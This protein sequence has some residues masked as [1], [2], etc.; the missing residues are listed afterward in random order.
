[1]Q[2]A[3]V[4]AL[5]FSTRRAGVDGS[6]VVSVFI[7]PVLCQG[8]RKVTWSLVCLVFWWLLEIFVTIFNEGITNA[9]FRIQSCLYMRLM[10]VYVSDVNACN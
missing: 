5:R 2:P 4:E 8:A 10:Q 9:V 3:Y 6:E 1:M 7:V